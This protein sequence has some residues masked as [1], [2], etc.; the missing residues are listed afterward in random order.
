MGW[1]LD[2]EI[3]KPSLNFSDST[4][5]EDVRLYRASI[6]VTAVFG[7]LLAHIFTQQIPSAFPI[8]EPENRSEAA[9]SHIFPVL[10]EQLYRPKPETQQFRALS[11]VTA[12]GKGRITLGEGFHTLTND[13]TVEV[14]VPGGRSGNAGSQ[15]AVTREGRGPIVRP[16]SAGDPAA[17]SQGDDGRFRI[18]SNYRFRQ[19][20]VLAYDGSPRFSV[21]RQELAG[22]RYFQNMF[23]RIRETFAPP[24]LNY[25]YQDMAGTVVNQPIKPQIVEVAFVIDDDGNVRD[26][27]KISSMGQDAVDRACMETLIG[28]NFGKPPPEIFANGHVFGI[29]FVFPAVMS[30]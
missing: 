23:R 28:Q 26:V 24:G 11:D 30:R 4:K 8:L 14:N 5:A 29:G 19:D 7:L 15:Q 18:P 21:A 13:D 17:Q 10:V 20:F 25:A 2:T 1:H 22:F 12:E 6:P 16:G 27:K 3:V 9:D